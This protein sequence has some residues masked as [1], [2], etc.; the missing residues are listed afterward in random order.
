MSWGDCDFAGDGQVDYK[1][2]NHGDCAKMAGHIGPHEDCAGR[3]WWTDTR[4]KLY[5][6]SLTEKQRKSFP[7]CANV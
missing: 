5:W 6:E 4:K 3:E 7:A 1:H 2:S